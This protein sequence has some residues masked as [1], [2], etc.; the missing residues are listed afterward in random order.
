MSSPLKVLIPLNSCVRSARL[1]TIHAGPQ[2]PMAMPQSTGLATCSCTA[3][4]WN[5]VATPLAARPP[6]SLR[7]L[8][9][10]TLVCLEVGYA[11]SSPLPRSQHQ[12]ASKHI[13]S[14]VHPSAHSSARSLQDKQRRHKACAPALTATSPPPTPASHALRAALPQPPGPPKRGSCSLRRPPAGRARLAAAA[15]AA[16]RAAG[17]ARQ[18][19]LT[20]TMTTEL[21]RSHSPATPLRCGEFSWRHSEN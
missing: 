20:P 6:I 9:L 18:L 4:P 15:A 17:D 12:R 14:H 5:S 2:S 16:A 21:R 3:G 7:C 10:Y 1:S 13:T 19:G 8:Y 11:Q